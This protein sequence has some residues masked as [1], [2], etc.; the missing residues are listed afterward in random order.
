MVKTSTMTAY[1]ANALAMSVA[2]SRSGLCRR[3]K[4]G[5]STAPPATGT[6]CGLPVSNCSSS[7]GRQNR[8]STSSATTETS[9]A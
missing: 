2:E 6:G 5:S 1:G 3:T 8:V 7:R 4:V 9:A